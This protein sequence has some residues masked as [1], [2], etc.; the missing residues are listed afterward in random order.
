[1]H[2][3]TLHNI[4]YS[5][6]ND[7]IAYIDKKKKR[8]KCFK[9]EILTLFLPLKIY[10]KDWYDWMVKFPGLVRL[11]RFDFDWHLFF[12]YFANISEKIEFKDETSKE[13]LKEVAQISVAQVRFQN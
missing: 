6:F 11:Y 10:K 5:L 8:V 13:E 3:H 9:K 2:Q 7:C 12:M 4:C 1:M